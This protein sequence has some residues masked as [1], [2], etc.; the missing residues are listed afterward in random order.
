MAAGLREAP[1]FSR[2]EVT[3]YENRV[4][5]AKE[6]VFERQEA[7]VLDALLA[8][9]GVEEET[10]AEYVEH[11]YAWDG[12]EEVETERGPVEPDPLLMKL[13]ETEHLGRFT[14]AD[15]DGNAP[16]EAVRRFRRERVITAL[17]RYAWENRDEGFEVGD[18]DLSEIP[19]IRAVLDT[20]DWDDVRRLF[21]DLEPR[22][23]DDPP[24]DTETAR[25]KAA[26]LDRLVEAGYTRA[27]AELTTRKVMRE[28]SYEWD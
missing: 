3:E 28:V 27:G 10:V 22:Q 17:N 26:T 23:W 21:E 9:K 15:Y 19:V 1:M 7:D 2:A 18:V 11:V 8:E 12:E 20:H 5:P 14:D 24:A 4:A 25:V 16:S 13:F 6:F